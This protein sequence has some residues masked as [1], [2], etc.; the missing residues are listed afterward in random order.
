[1]IRQRQKAT[2][3]R[4]FGR[5][6]CAR[7]RCGLRSCGLRLE[8]LE[9]RRLLTTFFVEEGGSIQDALDAAADSPGAD[10][11]L[12]GAGTYTENFTIEDDNALTLIGTG[13]VTIE[14]GDAD[15]DVIK[16][17]GG[18]VTIQNVSIT[19]GDDGIDANDGDSLTLINVDVSGNDD[20]GVEAEKVGNVTIR[21]SNFSGNGGDGI[22]V[23]IADTL[24]ITNV[25]STGNG[26]E[27]VQTEEMGSVTI[28]N[29]NFSDNGGDGIKVEFADAVLITNV[30]STGN[31]D[32]IDLEVV[33]SITLRNVTV[34][35]N[36]DEGLEVDDSGSVLVIYGTFN[37]NSDDGIDIDDTRE[38]TLISVDAIGNAGSG[39]QAEA[40]NVE[41][42]R[43]TIIDGLFA[44]NGE[45]GLQFTEEEGSIGE[46]TL[47]RVVAR[48]NVE[49]GLDISADTV[50]SRRVV[51]EDNGEADNLP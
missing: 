33:E 14:A 18:N 49:S 6:D 51:S 39:F 30:S 16:V 44:N 27:G 3:K 19:G 10:T 31:D 32:G 42:E 13:E 7:S 1:M 38:I 2:K 50:T 34:N 37:N 4:W 11:V 25:S 17:K 46:V 29:S 35:D 47:T 23:D 12:L 28:R 36:D 26:D 15:K 22:R 5:L 8:P 9:Q 24:F 41:T 48:G 20:R 40:E 45:D 21:N 43:I